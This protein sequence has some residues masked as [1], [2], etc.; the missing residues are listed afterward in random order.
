MTDASNYRRDYLLALT[1]GAYRGFEVTDTVIVL[2][3]IALGI[4]SLYSG[5][6]HAVHPPSGN[7]SPCS[8]SS[9][10]ATRRSRSHL[11]CTGTN[12]KPEKRLSAVSFLGYM[13][14]K[15]HILST[16]AQT[17]SSHVRCAY[18]RIEY[19]MTPMVRLSAAML[20]CFGLTSWAST[21]GISFPTTIRLIW[22]GRTRRRATT[23][24]LT[25][26]LAALISS[27]LFPSLKGAA[28]FA[29]QR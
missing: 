25:F 15:A 24:Q 14:E 19:R 3:I 7:S 11:G 6:N 21:V 5:A 8:P 9:L 22:L 12:D 26:L 2:A 16:V 28:I 20:V 4:W 18:A 17:G 27:I 23:A 10:F 29:W 1:R 13:P